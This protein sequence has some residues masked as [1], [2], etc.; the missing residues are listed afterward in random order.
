MP[1]AEALTQKQGAETAAKYQLEGVKLGIREQRRQFNRARETLAPYVGAGDEAIAEQ[2]R[3]LGIGQPE[4]FSEGYIERH[5]RSFDELSGERQQQLIRRHGGEAEAR[6]Q[7]DENLKTAAARIEARNNPVSPIDQLA[8]DPIFLAL[9]KQGEDAILQN[10][11]ATG[12][13][14]GG[15]VQAELA[16]FRPNLLNAFM[17]QRYGNLA[18]ITGIG[19]ASATGQAAMGQQMGNVI[20]DLYGQAGQAKAG[21]ELAW[22]QAQI[23]QFS[24]AARVKNLVGTAAGALGVYKAAAGGF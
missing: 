5:Q 9:A 22:R 12:G 7:W 13:L 10:A 14:R 1:L 18:N 21:A 23:D 6:Q 2:L 17:Q 4:P 11:S 20:T 19:Q 16:Q 3:M 8:Q 24:P 15:N